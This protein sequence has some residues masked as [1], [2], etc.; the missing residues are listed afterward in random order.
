M[1][2]V[3]RIYLFFDTGVM[4]TRINDTCIVLIPKTK[5]PKELKDFR[6]ISLCNIIHKVVS[7]CIINRLRPLLHEIIAPTQALLFRY[8]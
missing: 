1:I 2:K 3:A 4:K 6:P 5:D 7:K 8:G